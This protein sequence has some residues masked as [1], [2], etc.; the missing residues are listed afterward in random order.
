MDDNNIKYIVDTILGEADVNTEQYSID[1]RIYDVN[2]RY[3]MLIEQISQIDSGVPISAKES[4]SED[5]IIISSITT[6]TLNRT[7]LDNDIIRVDFANTGSDYYEPI[8]EN[9]SRLLGELDTG[10]INYIA[11]DKQ[12]FIENGRAGTVR[13]TY[14]HGDVTLF[15]RADYDLALGWPIP[16]F[17]PNTFRP[18]LWLYPALIQAR[19]YKSDRVASLLEQYTELNDMFMA[20]Y[21]RKSG[22]DQKVKTRTVANR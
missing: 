16:D 10:T 3:L 15:T 5:F 9:T 11:T 21:S 14:S 22:T 19:K 12:L 18:L 1:K 8:K 7:I 20:K 2:R 13:V 17:V 6:Q 4:F